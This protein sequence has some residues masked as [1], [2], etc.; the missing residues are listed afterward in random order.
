MDL[1]KELNVAVRAFCK[2][3]L[4][5]CKIEEGPHDLV[6]MP[7][8]KYSHLNAYCGMVLDGGNPLEMLTHSWRKILD[9]GIPEFVMFMVE[10]YASTK[11][12]PEEI[13]RSPLPEIAPE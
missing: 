9:D 13:R 2:M 6:P 10:G 4:S 5:V 1:E 11:N 8:F 7:H 3:K 12:V